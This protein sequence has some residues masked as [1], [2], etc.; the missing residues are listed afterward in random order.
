MRLLTILLI[1]ISFIAQA[2]QLKY[3]LSMDIQQKIEHEIC[4]NNLPAFSSVKPFMQSDFQNPGD[5]DSLVYLHSRDNKIITKLK[6][7]WWW[8]K[9][10]TEDLLIVDKNNFYLAVN[11]LLNFELDYNLE[12][13]SKISPSGLSINTRG[14]EVKGQVGENISFGS[15]FYENQGFFIDYVNNYINAHIVVPGQGIP[16]RFKTS[17]HDYASVSGYFSYSPIKNFNFQ[18]GHGKHFI[19]NG[20]RS[21]LLS[22]FAMSYP[23]IK[24]TTD[25]GKFRYTNLLTEFSHFDTN[26]N[27][28][29]YSSGELA[30]RHRKHGSFIIFSYQPV[31]QI[32]ISLFEGF[33]WQT[34]IDSTTKKFSIHYFNPFILS[35][36]LQYGLNDENNGILGVNIST[37]LSRYFQLYAQLSVDDIDLRH[38]SKK[39]Y[40]HNRLGGQAGVKIF[41]VFN[42]RFTNQRL[43]LQAEYN[44]V[45]PYMFGH[46]I[47]LQ[48]YSHLNQPLAHPLEASFT[49]WIGILHYRFRDFSLQIKMNEI[50]TA[51]DSEVSHYGT[52]IFISDLEAT[53]GTNSSGN[54]I[55]QGIATDISHQ[56][57]RLGYLINPVTNLQLFCGWHK[58]NRVSENNKNIDNFVYFG[59]QTHLRN[60]YYDF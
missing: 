55:G 48:N 26:F 57:I 42:K 47:I 22:D 53:T 17:G 21:L 59:L 34:E 28:H 43:Y 12:A 30:Y 7:P 29:G 50:F 23:Y 45:Q 44:F 40:F 16:R 19:G 15:R 25:I 4:V 9:L 11:P 2:Q 46:E 38:L 49:E 3:P 5:I 41:D 54:K 36:S 52:S 1:F 18:L 31:E 33:V 24:F 6:N 27:G 60:L 14:V 39:G 37:N 13:N 32:E 35:R 8:E 51:G 20:Y 56:D 10:R 58:R